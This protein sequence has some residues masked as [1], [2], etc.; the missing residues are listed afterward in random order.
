MRI[1]LIERMLGLHG[2][3]SGPGLAPK[4]LPGRERIPVPVIAATVFKRTILSA[5][6]TQPPIG[7]IV[8]IL[9]EDT[10]EIRTDHLPLRTNVNCGGL[11]LRECG[12]NQARRRDHQ[13]P[14]DSMSLV[15]TKYRLLKG[16]TPS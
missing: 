8:Q 11:F 3:F 1:I 10:K 7:G 5:F 2:K 4:Q 16:I 13:D 9:K 12:I 6:G 14:C 15:H